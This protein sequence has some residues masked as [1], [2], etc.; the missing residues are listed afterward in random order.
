MF[1]IFKNKPSS[2]GN[3][4][5][6]G[7]GTEAVEKLAKLQSGIDACAMPIAVFDEENYLIIWNKNYQSLYA[8]VWHKLDAPISY[9]QMCRLQLEHNG[10][11]GDFEAEVQRRLEKQNMRV[12]VADREYSDGTVLRVTKTRSREKISVG[13]GVDVSDIANREKAVDEWL[14]SFQ[15]EMEAKI[16]ISCETMHDISDNLSRTSEELL[17]SATNTS[18]KTATIRESAHDMSNALMTANQQ[19]KKTTDAAE[20]ATDA[21][22]ST[23][24]QF[25]DLNQAMERI[26]DFATTIQAIADQTNLLALNATIEAARAGE[27]GRGFAV[28]AAEVKTLSDQTSK[29]T[30]EINSQIS[31]VLAVMKQ[32]Q[33]AFGGIS[34]TTK[35]IF[36]LSSSTSKSVEDQSGS[37]N[38]IVEHI[39]SLNQTA[40]S[41]SESAESVAGLASQV[42]DQTTVLQSN[43]ADALKTGLAKL[44]A[45]R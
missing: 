38:E 39:A 5:N 35:D 37:V 27:A 13:I 11:D 26:G 30:E 24:S 32:S 42:R 18:V 28:V 40:G 36:E 10:Y 21:V 19:A 33:T 20:R 31:N 12:S 23:E 45:Q 1:G 16:N 8:D 17:G 14:A 41:A 29:A 7:G 43:F 25:S 34:L 22:I 2:V 4:V 9:E 3:E 6:T 15:S 44:T